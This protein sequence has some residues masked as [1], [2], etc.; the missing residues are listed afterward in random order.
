MASKKQLFRSRKNK[1]LFGVLG[2]LGDYYAID[3]T[4]LRLAWI[5]IVVFTGFV[6]GIIAYL[7]AALIMPQK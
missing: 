4:L 7:L 6:P 2:G 5:L 1:I 3:P